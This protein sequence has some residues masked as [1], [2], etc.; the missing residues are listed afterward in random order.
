MVPFAIGRAATDARR[1]ERPGP[2]LRTDEPP[3][4]EDPLNAAV[5]VGPV[6]PGLSVIC[7]AGLDR[8]NGREAFRYSV[9]RGARE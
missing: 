5:R 3:A 8:V 6:T 7:R 1:L 2:E 9:R 4:S